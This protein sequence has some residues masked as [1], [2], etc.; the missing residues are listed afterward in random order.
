M[1]YFGFL[2]LFVITPML[3]FAALNYWDERRGLPMPTPLSN[4]RPY[5]I[6]AWL[7]VVAVAYT[8]PWDNYLV[9]TR[10]WWYDPDLVTGFVIWYVPIEEYTFFVVQ[11]IMTGLFTTLLMRRMPYGDLPTTP[12]ASRRFRARA[13]G[14]VAVIWILSVILL[15]LSFTGG[16]WERGTYLALE[17]SWAL[18]PIML[19][20]AVG[21]DILWR[22]RWTVIIAILTT[23]LYLSATDAVAI[24]SGTWTINPEQSLPILIGGV[25]PIEEALFFLVTN[26]LVVFGLTLVLEQESEQRVPAAFRNWLQKQRQSKPVVTGAGD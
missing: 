26:V 1:T 9:A 2:F 16:V 10:V 22:H 3:V 19:Q 23:W 17:L 11:T 13:T 15:A 5:T 21:A 6:I 18:I 20:L 7:V 12:A 24:Q 8:T 25:L 4:W 14:V